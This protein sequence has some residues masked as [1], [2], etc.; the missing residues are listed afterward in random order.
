V[1]HDLKGKPAKILQKRKEGLYSEKDTVQHRGAE[2]FEKRDNHQGFCKRRAVGGKFRPRFESSDRCTCT[3]GCFSR[4]GKE[5]K[6]KKNQKAGAVDTSRPV[7]LTE[8]HKPE[9]EGREVRGKKNP[10]AQKA[11]IVRIRRSGKRKKNMPV[12]LLEKKP[13]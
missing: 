4:E 13:W 1:D 10:G 5:G 8:R 11:G 7:I 2:G 12:G 3:K 9:K 6:Q